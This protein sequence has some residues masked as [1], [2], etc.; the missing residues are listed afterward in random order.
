[1]AIARRLK[2]YLDS[3]GLDYELVHHPHSATSLET[4][5]AAALPEGRLAKSVLLEDERGYLLAVLPAS[6]RVELGAIRQQLR[7]RME[8]ASEAELGDLFRD[9][10]LG[11]VP[12]AG[13]AYGI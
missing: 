8:L 5:E 11:A 1:M 13:A 2:W 7:R 12:A 6:C 3:H 9:C 4:A 10:E